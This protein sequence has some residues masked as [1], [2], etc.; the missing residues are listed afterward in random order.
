M[1]NLSQKK[2]KLSPIMKDIVELMR[3]GYR[4]EAEGK[5]AICFYRGS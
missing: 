2:I 3:A 5:N 4:L 1:R